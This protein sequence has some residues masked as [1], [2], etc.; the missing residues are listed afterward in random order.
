MHYGLGIV[1]IFTNQNFCEQWLWKN[2]LEIL[3]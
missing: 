3:L 2:Y 1:K